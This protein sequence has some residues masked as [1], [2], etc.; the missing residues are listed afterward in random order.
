MN[1]NRIKRLKK[2]AG[3]MDVIYRQ[4][5]IELARLRSEQANLADQAEGMIDWLADADVETMPYADLALDRTVKL[6]G[7]VAQKD[8]DIASELEVV[9]AALAGVK[10]VDLHLRQERAALDRGRD[11]AAL[12]QVIEGVVRRASLE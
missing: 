2:L 12:E 3:V 1:D 8:V 7:E 6:K 11:Q 4:Q 9:A 10:G 5:S